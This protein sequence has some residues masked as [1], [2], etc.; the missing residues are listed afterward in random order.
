MA[1][2]AIVDNDRFTRR[3]LRGLLEDSGLCD[4]LWDRSDGLVAEQLVM[5]PESRPDLLLLDMSLGDVSGVEVCRAIRRR[6]AGVR[7]LGIT[8]FPPRLYAPDLASAGAQGLVTKDVDEELLAGVRAVLDNRTYCPSVPS[9]RFDT[10]SAAFRRLNG[11]ADGVSDGAV[12]GGREIGQEGGQGHGSG[13]GPDC[14]VP[15]TAATSILTDRE[16]A[17]LE[18]YARTGSYKA[19]ARELGVTDSTARNTMTRIKRKLGVSSTAAAILAW[20]D[21]NAW[22]DGPR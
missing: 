22:M 3:A 20:R 1:T 9:I 21:L 6:S 19:I 14:G 7:I 2:I 17:L 13:A 12:S 8:A 4:V 10:A 18:G 16:T 11:V 15:S 5:R